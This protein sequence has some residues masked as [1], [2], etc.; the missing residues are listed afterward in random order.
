MARS[1]KPNRGAP[2]DQQKQRM[3]A[4][5]ARDSKRFIFQKASQLEKP[6]PLHNNY[7]EWKA[8]CPNLRRAAAG[9]K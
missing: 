7:M 9:S 1:R 3:F 8:R 6:G 4:R 2:K 5:A